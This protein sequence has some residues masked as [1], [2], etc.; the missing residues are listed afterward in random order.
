MKANLQ[1]KTKVKIANPLDVSKYEELDLIIDTGAAFSVIKKE[2]LKRL[3]VSPIHKKKLR[4]ANG[5]IIERD[6]GDACFMINGK[7]EGVSD[8]IFGEKNDTELLGLLALEGMAS[9]VDTKT[10]E[11]KPIELFLLMN[12][13]TCR[14]FR[15]WH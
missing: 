1:L 3:G 13:L 15:F 11:L 2:R 4:L 5:E 12:S 10:G 8:V 6:W 14:G 7:G 9:T